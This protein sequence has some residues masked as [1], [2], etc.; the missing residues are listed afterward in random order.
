MTTL[1]YVAWFGQPILWHTAV[2]PVAF[3]LACHFVQ[4]VL[5]TAITQA[6]ISTCSGARLAGPVTVE[7]VMSCERL[8]KSLG[9]L[10]G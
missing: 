8:G 3:L 1:L 7:T 6:M 4:N 10:A 9:A 5:I 2:G